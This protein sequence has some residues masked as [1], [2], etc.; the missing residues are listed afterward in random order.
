MFE[1]DKVYQGGKNISTPYKKPCKAEST[2]E[3]K[4]RNKEFSSKGIFVE[5]VIILVKSPCSSTKISPE[6]PNLRTSNSYYLWFSYITS[7]FIG[8][9]HF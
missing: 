3:E 8:S 5:H 6:F 1:G 2:S 4:A 7:W 9:A